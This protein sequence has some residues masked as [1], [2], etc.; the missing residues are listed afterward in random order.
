MGRV[1]IVAVMLLIGAGPA[2]T[3]AGVPPETPW[4]CPGT[5]PIKGYVSFYASRVDQC[6]VDDELVTPQPGDFYGGWITSKVVGPFK[7][8]PGTTGW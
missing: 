4:A 6:F 5:H 1:A 3:R 2:G 7:G 8:D